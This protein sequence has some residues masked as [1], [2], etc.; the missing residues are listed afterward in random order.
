M[1]EQRSVLR[2]RGADALQQQIVEKKSNANAN[3]QPTITLEAING[4]DD[5]IENLENLDVSPQMIPEIDD[6]LLQRYFELGS[7]IDAKARSN[8]WLASFL[9]DQLQK[10]DE[11]KVAS[12]ALVDVLRKLQSYTRYTKVSQLPIEISSELTFF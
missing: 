7:N 2:M 4:V 5:L 3:K 12:K 6:P 9:N 1:I 10:L 11:K 8:E